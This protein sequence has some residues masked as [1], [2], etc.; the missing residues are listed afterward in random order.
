MSRLQEHTSLA[1][2]TAERRVTEAEG[3]QA[4]THHGDQ[5]TQAR[6]H[7]GS[8]RATAT[9]CA[10]D[11]KC[12]G[13][14]V[15]PGSR[16]GYGSVNTVS[17]CRSCQ[18]LYAGNTEVILSP[19]RLDSHPPHPASSKPKPASTLRPWAARRYEGLCECGASVSGGVCVCPGATSQGTLPSFTPC[20]NAPGLKKVKMTALVVAAVVP[21]LFLVTY[22]VLTYT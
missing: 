22:I 8:I 20:C 9:A 19:S 7:H 16:S 15:H 14:E 4:S 11:E 10:R 3:R 13:S 2:H 12:Q 1:P 17:V 6:C 5:R 18:H 21:W